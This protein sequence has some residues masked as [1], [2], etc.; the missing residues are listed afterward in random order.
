MFVRITMT[1]LTS[2]DNWLLK[3]TYIEMAILIEKRCL[4]LGAIISHI[5]VFQLFMHLQANVGLH[6]MLT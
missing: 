3:S 6:I 1:A 2:L 4:A 5:A